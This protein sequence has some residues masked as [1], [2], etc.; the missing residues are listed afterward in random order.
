MHFHHVRGPK[1]FN[2]GNSLGKSLATIETEIAKC[3]ILCANCHILRH[4]DEDGNRITELEEAMG[5]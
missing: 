4:I 3:V 2:I 5:V 1:L